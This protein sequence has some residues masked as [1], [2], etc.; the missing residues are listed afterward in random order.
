MGIVLWDWD[1]PR[2]LQSSVAVRH[3]SS[4]PNAA[5]SN[6][7]S[8]PSIL[9]DTNIVSGL[10]KG[11]LPREQAQ[12]VVAIVEMM[13]RSDVT[14]TGTTVMRDE[15]NK[16][17]AQWRNSH[18]AV[19]DTLR[20]LKTASGVTWLDPNAGAVVESPTYAALRR[21]HQTSPTLG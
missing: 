12:A 14:I 6:S 1:W 9:V 19:A 4:M 7:S 2:A 17:P 20:T 18:V 16:I 13:R 15:L 21:N 8:V 11:D 5:S 10:V 3:A